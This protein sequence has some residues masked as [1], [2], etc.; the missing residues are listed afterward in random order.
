[1]YLRVVNAPDFPLVLLRER[2]GV[3]VFWELDLI[4][5]VNKFKFFTDVGLSCFQR[6]LCRFYIW[7][8]V[9]KVQESGRCC[10]VKLI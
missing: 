10:I 8:Y 6:K 5:I 3:V 1:M 9:D 7:I 2:D 4:D